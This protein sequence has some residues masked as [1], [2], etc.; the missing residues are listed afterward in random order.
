M[1]TSLRCYR[2]GESLERLSLPLARLDECPAC[3]VQLHVCRMCVHFAPGRPDEC[4]EDDA[5][6]VRDKRR[7]N[8]CDYFAPDPNAFSP[9]EI[10][11][12]GAA[13]KKLAAL[14]GE[15]TG[16]PPDDAAKSGAWSAAEDLFKK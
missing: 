4:N 11:A 13:R 16:A 10:E 9:E 14:F 7:A 12:E 3:G 1:A 5:L 15:D 6:E 2:C 8:F